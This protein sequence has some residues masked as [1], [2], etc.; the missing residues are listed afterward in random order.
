[1]AKKE[2][3]K[4]ETFETI[5]EVKQE[6]IEVNLNTFIHLKNLPSWAKTRLE[7]FLTINPKAKTEG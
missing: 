2:N 5:E 7:H 3:E 4:I 6:A 1:M